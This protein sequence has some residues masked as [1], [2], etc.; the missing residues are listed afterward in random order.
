MKKLAS[1]IAILMVNAV[2]VLVY[3]MTDL[4][5]GIANSDL[6]KMTAKIEENVRTDFVYAIMDLKVMIAR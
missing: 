1:I 3:A 4:K 6:A 2:M 5:E